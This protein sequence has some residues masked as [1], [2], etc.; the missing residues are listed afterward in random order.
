MNKFEQQFHNSE[1]Q[2]NTQVQIVASLE[3]V[4]GT[5]Y[6]FKTD[7]GQYLFLNQDLEQYEEVP[8][9]AI[10]SAI[11]KHG[12][13][14]ISSEQIFEFGKIKEFLEKNSLLAGPPLAEKK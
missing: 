11:I 14:P 9:I 7:K 5:R 10:A 2:P 4:G 12:Y 1:F 8:E 13:K 3:D 6:F